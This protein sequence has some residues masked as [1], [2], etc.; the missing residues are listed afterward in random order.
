M[1]QR[2]QELAQR[3]KEADRRLTRLAVAQAAQEKREGLAAEH[4]AAATRAAELAEQTAAEH[5]LAA[6]ELDRKRSAVEQ[7]AARVEQSQLALKRLRAEMG[8]V[9]RETLETRLATEELLGATLGAAPPATLSQSLGRI[10]AKLTEQYRQANLEL[11]EQR[12]ELER[13]SDG[14]R[15]PAS[16]ADRA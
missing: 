4:H 5:R 9:Q 6:A 8:H 12:K 2:E 14:T 7:R 10:R 16:E 15:R 13:V 3:E 1:L 11:A